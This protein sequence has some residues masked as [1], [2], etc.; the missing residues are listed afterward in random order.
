MHRDV[1]ISL[2]IQ[3]LAYKDSQFIFN[4]LYV[5]YAYKIIVAVKSLRLYEQ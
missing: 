4:A 5:I 3:T 2:R 1:C